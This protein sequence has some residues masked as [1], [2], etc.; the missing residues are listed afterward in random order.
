MNLNEEFVLLRNDAIA[1]Q[2][3]LDDYKRIFA[4]I[5]EQLVELGIVSKLN[6]KNVNIC[7]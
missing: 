6:P 7:N 3:E 1:M 5:V 2:N 4:N